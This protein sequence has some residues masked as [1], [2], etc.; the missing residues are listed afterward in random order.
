MGDA[1]K[2]SH[3]IVGAAMKRTKPKFKVGQVV[4]IRGMDMPEG[5]AVITGHA[6]A[7]QWHIRIELQG[8]VE[9]DSRTTGDLRPLTAKEK[10]GHV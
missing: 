10:N 3:R 8:H 5:A 7:E 6:G 4:C 1:R 2:Y 9:Y